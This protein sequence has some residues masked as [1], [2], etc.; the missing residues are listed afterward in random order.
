MTIRSSAPLLAIWLTLPAGAAPPTA[1]PT[2]ARSH[3]HMARS[4]LLGGA[5]AID[6][7]GQALPEAALDAHAIG[8]LGATQLL[9]ADY[10]ERLSSVYEAPDQA[11]TDRLREEYA[12]A[13]RAARTSPAAQAHL[14]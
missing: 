5:A 7:G 13:L 1:A 10:F 4:V 9:P 2:A 3:V 12:A 11:Q 6:V 14:R 8:I